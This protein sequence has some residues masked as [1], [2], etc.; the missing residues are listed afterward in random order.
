MIEREEKINWYKLEKEEVLARLSSDA[1]QGLPEAEAVERI[2]R[3]GLNELIERGVKSPWR[4]LLEQF[5]ET[6][7]VVLIIAAVISGL[8]GDLKDTIAIVAIVI[9]NGLLGFRQEY[10]AERAMAAL[11][12][13]AVPNV[14]VRRGGHLLELAANKLVP[15]DIIYLEAGNMVPA[16]SR[17]LESINLRTQESA[18]TGESEPVDK[19]EHSLA[20]KGV[21]LAERKNMVYMGT[22][23]TY[24]RGQAVVTETGMN[25]ELGNIAELMQTAGSESTPLQRRL[26]Q[27]GKGL[28]WAALGLVLLVS[29]I[30]I[31]RGED[32]ET[33]FLTA[34][35]L[36]VAAVPEGLP[37][38]VTISLALGARRMLRRKA[39]IRKLPAVEALGSVTVICSDKTGTLTENRMTVTVI[40]V[41]EHRVDLTEE[42]DRS[43]LGDI[44]TIPYVDALPSEEQIDYL[45]EKP[46][47]TLLLA[48][49]ALCNDAVLECEHERPENFYIV[50]DPTEG[51]LVVVAAR[52]G[53][54]KSSLESTFPRLAEVPFDSDRKRMTTIHQMP[55]VIEDIPEGFQLIWN[56][57]GWNE[58]VD[59]VAFTKGAI[60]GLLDLSANVWVEDR[61]EP[62]NEKWRQRIEA[63]NSK[64]AEE[65]M[66]VLGLAVRSV[67]QVPQKPNAE[68]IERDLTFIGLVGM[69]DP[70]R[71]EVYQAVNTCRQA[72][73]RP[74]MIT[75]DHPLTARYI[76]NELGISTNNGIVTGKDLESL[77][78]SELEETVHKLS[79]YARVSP[80]HKLKIVHALQNRGQIVAMTGD[81]VNDAPALKKADIGVAMGITGTDVSK[82]A[83]D[84][85]LLDDN[86]ATIVAAIEEGRI[87]YDNI[88]KF[89][90]YTMSSN[91]G[92]IW[93]MLIGPLLGMP[94][95]LLPLQILWINLVTDGLPGLALGVEKAERNTMHRP[96]YHPKENVFSRGIG[97]DILWVGLVM[98]LLSLG[99]GYW[100]WLR[101]LPTW[102]TMVFTTL[103]ISEMGFV[104]AIRSQRD[105]LFSIGVFSNMP[106]IGAVLLTATLQ[107]AVV[108]M[109]FLQA[110]FETV[111]LSITDLA[112]C[113]AASTFLFAV[114]EVQKWFFRVLESRSSGKAGK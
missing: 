36:A 64:I 37:A 29:A 26:D 41:A 89:I 42:I 86:F 79:V 63:A 10:Q 84:I 43:R 59:N 111:P 49:G 112:I 88:R 28:A 54:G 72:G 97:R 14:K 22:V 40:D 16:D 93:V 83:S 108:Y 23:V 8:L 19:T 13:L 73:V 113:L 101:D 110:I 53:L 3:F 35:S 21:S 7:V 17:L 75:G 56:W 31:S 91:M 94:L 6:M 102:Q 27:L 90:K 77:S 76:A 69:V 24:G 61:I 78:P 85:V 18:L 74:I 105:S 55:A 34:I 68:E 66:R 96:P 70:A 107:I 92:E 81:G 52:V 51:A 15:G 50:G 71:P 99:V 25:T 106:L 4:I 57:A 58:N 20:G 47:L 67:D 82:E 38:V 11:K 39:L 32:L 2:N 95:A 104:L 109:P 30:G 62:M 44:F 33:M 46:A 60:D 12:K 5:T 1:R 48:S 103:T 65:G 100:Y 98:G 87:I 114:V 80:E 45:K 9:L